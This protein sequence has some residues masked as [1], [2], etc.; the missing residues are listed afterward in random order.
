MTCGMTELVEVKKLPYSVAYTLIVSLHLCPNKRKPNRGLK[1]QVSNSL[2]SHWLHR[3][4]NRPPSTIFS[5]SKGP[6]SKRVLH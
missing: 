3:S 5:D 1:S 6:Y 4:Q 2:H